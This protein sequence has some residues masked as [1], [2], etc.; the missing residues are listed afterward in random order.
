MDENGQLK[1]GEEDSVRENWWGPHA[2]KGAA[3]DVG[4][5]AGLPVSE[6]RFWACGPHQ[7]NTQS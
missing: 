4:L 3:I 2:T 5:S 7:I 1:P 6:C